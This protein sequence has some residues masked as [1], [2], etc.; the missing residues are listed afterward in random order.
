MYQTQVS[1]DGKSYTQI[2]LETYEDIE[3]VVLAH[4]QG[5]FEDMK[6]DMRREG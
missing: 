1:K 4:H 5:L 3:R 6:T 2:V